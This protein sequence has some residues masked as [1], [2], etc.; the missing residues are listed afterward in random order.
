M[1]YYTHFAFGLLVGLLSLDFFNIKNKILFM[2]IAL[3]FSLFPDIDERRSKIG[4]KTKLLSGII[5]FI[6]GHR[7]LVHTI[8]IPLIL[9]FIFYNMNKETGIAVLIGYFSHLFMDA[10][11]KQGIRPLYPIIN[12]RIDGCIRTNSLL[13]KILFLVIVFLNLGILLTYI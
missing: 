7:G 12:K 9:F 4:K 8:Y 10:M 13:E 2:L 5:N 6:F 1:M 3:F 11:T